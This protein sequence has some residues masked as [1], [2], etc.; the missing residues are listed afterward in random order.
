MLFA[1]PTTVKKLLTTV[2]APLSIVKT[3]FTLV[4]TTENGAFV[5]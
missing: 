4:K 1:P 2:K 3:P 5:C